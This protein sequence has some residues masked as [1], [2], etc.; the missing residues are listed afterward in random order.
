MRRVAGPRALAPI[1][2]LAV[3]CGGGETSSRTVI[4]ETGS[5]V[6]VA[7]ARAWADRYHHVDR[8]VDVEVSGGGSEAG[9]AALVAGSVDVANASRAITPEELQRAR[10]A[11][12]MPIEHIVAY[13]ALVVFLNRDNP[14][15]SITVPQL[16]SIFGEDG[17]VR[18]WSDLGVA[19]RGCSGE[20]LRVGWSERSGTY[21][22]FQETVLGNRAYRQ[23]TRGAKGSSDVIDVVASAPCAIGYGSLAQATRAVK[24][25][26][27]RA[28]AGNPCMEPS[29][30]TAVD[31]SYPLARP[32]FMYTSGLPEGALGSYMDWILGD[33]GQC[34]LGE[35][36]FA[37]ALPVD[38]S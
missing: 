27:V 31:G 4:R 26:C 3:A 1:L 7:G 28:G 10:A 36:G 29:P 38:C 2:L 11:G 18:S 25:P 9:I 19:V 22:A 12:R 23:G 14:I 34:L 16:A 33:E 20:I 5:E 30:A 17:S 24:V 32:L 15:D 6:M 13:D 35:T 8:S 21:E 37:P